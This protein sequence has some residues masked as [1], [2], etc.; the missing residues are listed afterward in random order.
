MENTDERPELERLLKLEYEILVKHGDWRDAPENDRA[1]M[2]LIGARD[3]LQGQLKLLNL[4]FVRHTLK[5]Y[6]QLRS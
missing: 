3:R 5:N 6:E 1:S 2:L 4:D